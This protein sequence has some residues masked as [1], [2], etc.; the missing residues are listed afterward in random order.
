MGI[1]GI[2]VTWIFVPNLK[3][4]DLAIEDEKFRAQN[5]WQGVMGE[6][7]LKAFADVG[8]PPALVQEDRKHSA[9]P[10]ILEQGRAV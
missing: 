3:G 2:L 1:V 4:E 8:I 5:G 9:L 10:E 7:D 6:D